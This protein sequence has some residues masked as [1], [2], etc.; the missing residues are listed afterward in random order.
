[1]NEWTQRWRRCVSGSK[2]RSTWGDL[3]TWLNVTNFTKNPE[4]HQTK[5]ESDELEEIF[6]PGI[7]AG[8]CVGSDLWPW[9]IQRSP[10]QSAYNY[11]LLREDDG[12]ET[13]RLSFGAGLY[14]HVLDMIYPIRQNPNYLFYILSFGS[15]KCGFV[16]LL[17]TISTFFCEC[18]DSLQ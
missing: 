13:S 16:C 11:Q 2:R 18:L 9:V 15:S 14:Q 12:W 6:P 7:C 8:A 4:C 1:M 5:T 3:N 10:F 17:S